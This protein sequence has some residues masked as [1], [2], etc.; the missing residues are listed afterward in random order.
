MD[1]ISKEQRSALMKHVKQ[2]GTEQEMLVR[3]GLHKRGLRYVIGDRRLP[4]RP[5]LSFPKYRAVVFVHGCFWPGH[6]FGRGVA[7]RT[8]TDYWVPKITA[9][10]VRDA[11]VESELVALGWRV[12]VVW[13][14]KLRN[15]ST[16]EGVLEELAAKIVAKP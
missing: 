3:R 6:S 7:S 16:R 13:G 2:S 11:K 12:F 10:K 8:N 5:D 15:A 1:R 14:C 4:G 9:N